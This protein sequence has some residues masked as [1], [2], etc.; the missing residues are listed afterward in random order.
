M[1]YEYDEWMILVEEC[2]RAVCSKPKD[3]AD[4]SVILTIGSFDQQC[5]R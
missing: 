2:K 5:Y 1:L 4:L 3:R